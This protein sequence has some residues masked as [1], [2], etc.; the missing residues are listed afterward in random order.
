MLLLFDGA[1]LFRFCVYIS[2]Y[3]LIVEY[4]GTLLVITVIAFV[5]N[6]YAVG[7]TVTVAILLGQTVSGAHFNPAASVWAWLSGK[8]PTSL[9][10]PYILAQLAAAVTVALLHK[11]VN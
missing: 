8:L 6:P 11:T 4:L 2:M 9:L 1:R 5:N 3:P 10:I 7:A